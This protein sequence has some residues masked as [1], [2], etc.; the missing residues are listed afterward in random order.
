MEELSPCWIVL[1]DLGIRRSHP[2]FILCGLAP[3]RE[4]SFLAVQTSNAV[5]QDLLRGK[6]FTERVSLQ[7][8]PVEWAQWSLVAQIPR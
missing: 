8:L 7:Q 5:R 6:F 4:L 1:D 2:S 3:L